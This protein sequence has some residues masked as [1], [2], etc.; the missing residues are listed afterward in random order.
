MTRRQPRFP[1]GAPAERAGERRI[2]RSRTDSRGT[3]ADQHESR[4]YFP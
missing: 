3:D 4:R 2:T 1:D